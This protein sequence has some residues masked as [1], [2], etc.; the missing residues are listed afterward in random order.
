[1]KETDDSSENESESS[2][3]YSRSGNLVAYLDSIDD[4]ELPYLRLAPAKSPQNRISL[5]SYD[6]SLSGREETH[7]ESPYSTVPDLE[8]T[9]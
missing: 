5:A 2:D 9:Q 4:W 6:G 7:W 8:T 1:M 3:S